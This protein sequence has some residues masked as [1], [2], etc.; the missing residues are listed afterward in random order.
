MF[1]STT[2]LGRL[3]A[4]PERKQAKDGSSFVRFSVAYNEGKDK[5][6]IWYPCTAGGKTGDIVSEHFHKGK[7]ILVQ[8]IMRSRKYTK[9]GEEKTFWGLSVH[10]VS[11]AGGK[12]DDSGTP[13]NTGG[14]GGGSGSNSADMD[15]VPF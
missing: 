7:M 2:V 4:D 9:D 1:S 5:P 8:G 13:A 3:G 12:N 10:R 15:D 14:N 6:T 11:F